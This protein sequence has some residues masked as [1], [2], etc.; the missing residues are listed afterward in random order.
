MDQKQSEFYLE[1]ARRVKHANSLHHT[2]NRLKEC[3]SL[4]QFL[5]RRSHEV[6]ILNDILLLALQKK[7]IQFTCN[8]TCHGHLF[9]PIYD[10]LSGYF[11]S[12][13][14]GG[15]DVMFVEG[16]GYYIREQKTCENKHPEQTNHQNREEISQQTREE[17]SQQIGEEIPQRIGEEI[18]QEE[19]LPISLLWGAEGGE[20]L[21]D[22]P[23]ERPEGTTW[24]QSLSIV[25]VTCIEGLSYLE[26]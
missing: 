2:S 25:R 13:R 20:G 26:F 11:R 17:I 18:S 16:S 9:W 24:I 10:T 3:I 4:F 15:L 23:T 22:I 5:I 1:V 7:L 21:Y 14:L 8:P 19:Q 6:P 12:K